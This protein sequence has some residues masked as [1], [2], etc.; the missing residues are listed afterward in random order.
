MKKRKYNE[1][2]SVQVKSSTAYTICSIIQKSL[3]LITLPFFSRI[4]ST[5]E[6]GLSTIYSSTMAIV[7]LFTSLQLPYGTFNTAMVKFEKDRKGYVSAIT[8]LCTLLTGLF[9]AFYFLSVNLWDRY[10]NLSR[11]FIIVMG[12]E[13]LMTTS[14]N[15][16]MGY[17]RFE[18]RYKAVVA[19]TLLNSF[20]STISAIILIY[21]FENNRGEIRVLSYSVTTILIG[22]VIF[23][24]NFFKGKK[25]YDY[26]YWSYAIR[27]NI[28]L[29]PYYISQMIFNQSDRLMIDYIC[30]RSD[31]A[32]YGVAYSLALIISFVIN[33]IN[34]SYTPWLYA[35]IKDK[36]FDIN[37]KISF[38]LALFV[39]LLLFAVVFFAPELVFVMAG[40]K[41]RDVV[42][43]IGPIAMSLLFLFYTQLFV[44]FEFYFEEKYYLVGG[45]IASALVNIVLNVIFIKKY[46]YIAAAYTTLLSFIIFAICNYVCMKLV[47]NKHKVDCVAYDIKKLIYLGIIFIFL[48]AISM[49]LYN[50]LYLRLMIVLM[51]LVLIILNYKRIIQLLKKNISLLSK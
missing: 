4:L 30:G 38:L 20:I 48:C 24:I 32:K 42:W 37:Q 29:L 26:N 12:I 7:I 22:L 2:V 47:C 34:D 25:F 35:R 19:V 18:Y 39:A 27:F 13:M 8:G 49:F 36:D 10:V 33:A 45:S 50:Y 5:S 21:I 23:C 46:G 11:T 6:Y 14:L 44:N 17:Q 40:A 31:V 28:P 51:A 3:S 41:Y 15:L 43:A 16:W 9:F 1:K